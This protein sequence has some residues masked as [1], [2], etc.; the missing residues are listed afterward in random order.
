MLHLAL[1]PLTAP[2]ALPLTATAGSLAL[3]A[4]LAAPA[5]GAPQV[6]AGTLRAPEVATITFSSLTAASALASLGA[7]ACLAG[8]PSARLKGSPWRARQ[9]AAAGGEG[10]C[11]LAGGRRPPARRCPAC[12]ATVCRE[13]WHSGDG[14]GLA[15]PIGEG[16][17]LWKE[18]GAAVDQVRRRRGEREQSR[19]GVPLR[20]SVSQP[21]SLSPSLPLSPSLS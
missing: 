3:A 7:S 8:G 15:L 4:A 14:R 6:R 21:P 20:P 16:P 13:A 1:A 17:L 9:A 10:R 19:E 11:T 12:G 2:F 5:L 18:A